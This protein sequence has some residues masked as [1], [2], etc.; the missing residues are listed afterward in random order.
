MRTQ[1][2]D[3]WLKETNKH[4]FGHPI[5]GMDA[6]NCCL[7]YIE[8][9]WYS[10]SQTQHP[11]QNWGCMSGHYINNNV[12]IYIYIYMYIYIICKTYRIT[13]VVNAN[14]WNVANYT[15]FHMPMP[16]TVCGTALPSI[17]NVYNCKACT[18]LSSNKNSSNRCILFV[19]HWPNHDEGPQRR[20][21]LPEALAFW[22]KGS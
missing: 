5:L 20:S 11:N 22:A 16:S 9:M 1:P 4:R 3:W 21:F 7:I 8:S 15:H 14:S 13:K 17:I 19:A 2:Q 6:D 12:C 18:L 10:E